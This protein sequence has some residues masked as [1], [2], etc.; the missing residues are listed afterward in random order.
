MTIEMQHTCKVSEYCQISR[1]LFC[2]ESAFQSISEW[3]CYVLFLRII[4]HIDSACAGNI[5]QQKVLLFNQSV[6]TCYLT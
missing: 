3:F 1:L 5:L 4:N 6:L 2:N